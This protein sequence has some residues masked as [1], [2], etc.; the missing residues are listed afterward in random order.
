MNCY[1]KSQK[2]NVGYPDFLN[3]ENTLF[4]PE[5]AMTLHDM[6]YTGKPDIFH[7]V[8]D[9]PFLVGLYKEEE[10]FIFNEKEQ[11]WENPNFQTYGTSYN[12]L[13]NKLW[14]FRNTIPITVIGTYEITNVMGY[15]A[16][17]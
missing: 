15:D 5:Q 16:K 6:M 14:G 2:S 13:L 9:C 3:K 7:I 1:I 11:K 8:T 12:I 10:V 17:K 4:Y